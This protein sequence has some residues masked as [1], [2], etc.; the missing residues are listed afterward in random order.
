MKRTLLLLALLVALLLCGPAAAHA[1]DDPLTPG[2][3]VEEP[4]AY[5]GASVVVQGEAIGDVLR[6][7]DEHRWV[8]V[9]G[10][11]AAIGVYMPTGMADEIKHLGIFKTFGDTVAVR[12]V[13]NLACEQH[14]GEFDIHAE[15]LEIVEPGGPRENPVDPWKLAMGLGL[16]ALGLVEYRVYRARKNRGPA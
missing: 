12:G 11:G 16:L 2:D 14:G 8:N 5:D 1:A 7:D 6:A 15:E 10:G 3:V 4:R 13:V 9:L